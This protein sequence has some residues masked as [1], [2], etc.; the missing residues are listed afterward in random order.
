LLR[1]DIEWALGQRKTIRIVSTKGFSSAVSEYLS[2]NESCN[3][4]IGTAPVKLDF[5]V[6]VV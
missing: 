4:W 5:G 6:H 1:K 2:L 3:R